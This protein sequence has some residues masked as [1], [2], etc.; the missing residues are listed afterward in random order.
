MLHFSHS[1]LPR[2]IDGQM[3]C[4][5]HKINVFGYSW[6]TFDDYAMVINMA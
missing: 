5:D 2:E 3:Y 4:R 1:S 6:S